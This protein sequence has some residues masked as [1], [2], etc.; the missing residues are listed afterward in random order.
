MRANSCARSGRQTIIFWEVKS[1]QCREIK[2]EKTWLNGQN[3]N[4]GWY[5]KARSIKTR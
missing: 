3:N 1:E 5:C 2:K 4:I